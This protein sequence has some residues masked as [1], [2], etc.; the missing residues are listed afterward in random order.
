MNILSSGELKE[1]TIHKSLSHLFYD[2]DYR[3]K[4]YL[5]KA[6]ILYHLGRQYDEY[7]GDL[8]NGDYNSKMLYQY[9][10]VYSWVFSIFFI[11]VSLLTIPLLFFMKRNISLLF[12]ILF[13]GILSFAL[14]LFGEIQS[15]YVF[16]AWMILPIYMGVSVISIRDSHL[17]FEYLKTNIVDFSITTCILVFLTAAG[18][19]ILFNRYSLANGKMFHAEDWLNEG[20][21]D[22]TGE[23]TILLKKGSTKKAYPMV[24][25]EV[26]IDN[27]P[28]HEFIFFSKGYSE[29]NIA[30]RYALEVKINQLSWKKNIDSDSEHPFAQ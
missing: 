29:Q 22:N 19:I 6:M 28:I 15:S 4:T 30:C 3:P 25:S 1:F 12:P 27:N 16:S 21:V 8:K 2:F 10:T 7:Y 18:L 9:F 11:V 14:L 17:R 5:K 23:F 13:L 20:T 24:L 26:N